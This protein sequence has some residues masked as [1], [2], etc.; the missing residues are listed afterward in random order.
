MIQYLVS[1]FFRNYTGLGLCDCRSLINMRPQTQPDSTGFNQIC[2]QTR[3]WM[4]R[5]IDRMIGWMD[6]IMGLDLDYEIGR[7]GLGQIGLRDWITRLDY[8]IELRGWITRLNYEIDESD[9]QVDGGRRSLTE[10]D[11]RVDGIDDQIDLD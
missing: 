1:C 8:E 3:G 2:R 11:N 7:V 10:I 6:W 4:D 9:K 5:T